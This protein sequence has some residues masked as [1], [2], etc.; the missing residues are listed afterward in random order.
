MFG[1]DMFNCI[2]GAACLFCMNILPWYFMLHNWAM[3]WKLAV[4]FLVTAAILYR[5]WYK[6][7]PTD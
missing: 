7:L 4:V 1:L 5:T 6:T 3:F 2:I